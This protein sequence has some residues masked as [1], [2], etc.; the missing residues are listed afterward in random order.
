MSNPAYFDP[1]YNLAEDSTFVEDD[2]RLLAL[3]GTYAV[4]GTL[5]L[6]LVPCALAL[7]LTHHIRSHR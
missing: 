5:T 7:N 3:L 2:V 4:L 1:G 6:L